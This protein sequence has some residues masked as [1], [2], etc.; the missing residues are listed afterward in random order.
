GP[1]LGREGLAGYDF[2]PPKLAAKAKGEL[3]YPIADFYL[4]NAICRASPT[5]QRCSAELI[6]GEDFAEAAE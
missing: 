5:M 1:A 4:T 6:H 3:R 2:S